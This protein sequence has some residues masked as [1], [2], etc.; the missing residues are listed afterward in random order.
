VDLTYN[1]LSPRGI[2][3]AI[4][5]NPLA[6]RLETFD[7]K[8]IWVNQG[9]ADPVIMPAVWDRVQK[10]FPK[11]TWKLIASSSF[12]PSNPEAEVLDVADA[13]IRGIGW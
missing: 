8:V 7:G 5:I 13:V 10:E 6:P 9:E 1:V 11:A 12:G 2:Q 3:P 4:Q